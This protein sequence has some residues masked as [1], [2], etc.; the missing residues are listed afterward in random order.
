[1]AFQGYDTR[2][3]PRRLDHM[4]AAGRSFLAHSPEAASGEAWAGLRPMSADDLPLVGPLPGWS[5]VTV[6]SGHGMLGLTTAPST[7]RLLAEIVA[8][9]PPHLDPGPFR[10]NRFKLMGAEKR[11]LKPFFLDIKPLL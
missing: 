5:N 2:L 1:M 11:L 8:K 9:R 3:N 7:G 10:L 6:A 4:A